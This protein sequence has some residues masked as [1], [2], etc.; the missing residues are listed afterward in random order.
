MELRLS[1][2]SSTEER[3]EWMQ[4]EAEADSKVT[5]LRKKE[6]PQ[7]RQRQP[8]PGSIHTE[9]EL[10]IKMLSKGESISTLMPGYY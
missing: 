5:T 10:H 3:E 2:I 7:S 6:T 4:E 9:N 1:R 8:G